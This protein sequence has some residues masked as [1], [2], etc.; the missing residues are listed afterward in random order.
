MKMVTLA[1]QKRYFHVWLEC[2]GSWGQVLIKESIT[3]RDTQAT[4]NTTAWLTDRQIVELYHSE[5][6]GMCIVNVKAKDR[7][8]WRFHPDAPDCMAAK[9]Y[10]VTVDDSKKHE[11]ANI[12]QR[13]IELQGVADGDGARHL[14]EQMQQE[15]QDV[16]GQVSCIPPAAASTEGTPAPNVD[17]KADKEEQKRLAEEESKAEQKAEQERKKQEAKERLEEERKTPEY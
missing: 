5:E 1:D 8:L 12:V 10:L 2:K 6:V 16:R 9:Q 3:N 15:A 17:Q 11:L 4:S 14:V 7:K 13:G